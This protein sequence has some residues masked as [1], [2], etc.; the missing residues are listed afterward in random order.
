MWGAGIMVGP[1][2]GPTLGGWLTETLNWRWVF[3]INLPVGIVAFLGCCRLSAG[4]RDAASRGFD[5]FGFAMLSLGVGALQLMLDRGGEVDWFSSPEI[6]I[7][8]VLSITGFWVFAVHIADGARTPFIDPHIFKDRNFV[9]GLVFIFVIGIILLASM[10][11]LPPMLSNIFGYPTITDR[12]GHGAARRRH[13]DLDDHGRPA[14]AAWSIARILVVA[15]LLLTAWSLYDDDRLLAADGS[16]P[17]HLVAA[18]S[19]ASAWAWSSCRCRR[20]PSRRSTAH[21]RTDA[22]SLF[23]LVRNIG[24]SIGI[25]IVTV[26]ADPQHPD[27]PRRA[28]RPRIDAVQ[29]DA[30]ARSRRPR[31]AG[32]PTAL[33]QID[34]LVNMQALMIAYIDDFK[35]MMIVTLAA[36]PLALLLRKPKA[37]PAAL[38]A[39]VHAD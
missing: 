17:D 19:R 8:L 28:C 12:P 23:S 6:W 32:D 9:T 38:P 1:I 39:A 24:S 21:Y 7:E 5:F 20:S 26:D 29:P 11:L 34:G 36:I 16:T 2:I 18:S 27:Q 4:N 22:A 25:S 10:A 13:D 14:G 37:A 31:P 15:G 30:L 33:S 3:F 35:L